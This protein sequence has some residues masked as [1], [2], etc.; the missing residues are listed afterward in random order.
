MTDFEARASVMGR[1]PATSAASHSDRVWFAQ[2]PHRSHRLRPA[3]SDEL[4]ALGV[5]DN[6][7][8][9]W[10]VVRQIA[11]GVRVRFA[12]TPPSAPPDAETV[13]HA[14]FD[15]IAEH[16]AT[17]VQHVPMRRVFERWREVAPGNGA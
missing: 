17:G 9:V 10:I 16:R 7:M 11:P 5:P 1:R 4:F 13:A 15:A 2:S 3:M 12:F 8:T 14:L 6:A